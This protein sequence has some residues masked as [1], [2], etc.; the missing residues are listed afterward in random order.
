MGV[1]DGNAVAGTLFDVFGADMTDANGIRAS[2]ATASLLGELK[3]SLEGR[4][5]SLAAVTTTTS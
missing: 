3:V 1:P 2:C 4:G 5:R